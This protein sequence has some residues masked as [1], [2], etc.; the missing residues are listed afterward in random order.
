MSTENDVAG[1]IARRGLALI[2]KVLDELAIVP[3]DDWGKTH[4]RD[5][6]DCVLAAVRVQA[7]ERAQAEWEK[8]N[9]LSEDDVKELIRDYIAKL[10]AAEFAAIVD[11]AK[12]RI[13]S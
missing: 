1:K 10:P 5:I 2:D 7:E 6:T 11:S 8:D 13:S 4:V 12:R 9:R 3:R